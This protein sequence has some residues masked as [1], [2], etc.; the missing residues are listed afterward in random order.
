MRQFKGAMGV[1]SLPPLARRIRA[2]HLT[3]L[4]TKKLQSLVDLLKVVDE[5]AVDGGYVEAGV[6]MGG[7]AILLA[8]AAKG[9]S[10]TF[11]GYDLFSQIPAPSEN[12]P[13]EVH[14]RYQVISQ[15]ESRGIG[16]ET[17]YGYRP[18]LYGY[19]VQKFEEFGVPLGEHVRLHQ[20]YFEDT[21]ELSHPVALAHIDCDWHDPVALCLD[22]IYP[23]LSDGG[24]IV[25][26]DYYD[27]GGCRV[28]TDEFRSRVSV[29]TYRDRDH[30][31]LRKPRARG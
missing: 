4:S 23:H 16:G 20:G 18:D 3:Y 6:A 19:V 22:R 26:D 24:F 12:D 15:G 7:S 28:A 1:L 9:R 5:E 13:A 8:T 29:E 21:L 10:I 14:E 11:D 2:E 30:L 17:Y 27:Y 31:V 25:V